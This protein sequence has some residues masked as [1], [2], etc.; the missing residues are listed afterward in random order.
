LQRTVREFAV[1]EIAP[2]AAEANAFRAEHGLGGKFVVQFSGN[3]GRTHD[4]ELILETAALLRERADI[5]FLFVGYGGKSPLVTKA[6]EAGLGNVRFLPRQ[7]RERLGEMLA[8][9]DATLIPLIEGMYGLSVPSRMYN[10]MAAGVPIVA[11]ADPRS[12]LA[13]AVAEESAGWVI[14][15]RSAAGLA[16]LIAS[17]ASSEGRTEAARRGAAG[18]QAVLARYTLDEMLDRYRRLLA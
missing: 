4:V 1:G 15:A 2:V 13:L 12:E 3:I 16:A 6:S 11:I 10:V 8:A 14:E 9:S 18:R 7:P 17:L 5:L